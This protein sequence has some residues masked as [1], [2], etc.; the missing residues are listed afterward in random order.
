M[1]DWPFELSALPDFHLKP[2]FDSAYFRVLCAFS[3]SI[4]DMET[5]PLLPVLVCVCVCEKGFLLFSFFLSEIFSF[6]TNLFCLS[7]CVLYEHDWKH[8]PHC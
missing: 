3:Y 4:P 7:F 1:Y 6:P 5:C 2:Q 8:F